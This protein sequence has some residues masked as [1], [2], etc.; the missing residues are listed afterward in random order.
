MAVSMNKIKRWSLTLVLFA[1]M[2][3]VTSPIATQTQAQ[4]GEIVWSEAINISNSPEL[5]STDPFLLADPAGGA[6]LFWAERAG[7]GA[8]LNPDTVMYSYWDGENWSRPIDIFFSP[9]SDGNPIVGY[10]H[11]L[12]DDNGRIHLFWLTEPNYPYYA[13]KYSSVEAS[14]ARF[15]AA[16]EPPVQL[17][18]D[19]TG[20]KYSIQIAYTPPD[21]LHL[22]Y[23]AGAQGNRPSEDRTVRYMRSTDLGE[24]W[25]EPLD[26]FTSPVLLW[27]TSDTRLISVSPGNLYASWTLWDD[28]GNGFQ[29]YFT[30]SRDNGLTWDTPIVLAEN[31]G[32]EYE[33]DWNNL[34]PLDK[35]LL[36]A[37]WEGGWRAYRQAQ[38][39]TDGGATWSEPIDT[40]P[41]LIGDNGFVEFAQDSNGTW[42]AFVAQRLR[43]GT[44]LAT[45]SDDVSLWHSVWQGG[46]SWSDPTPAISGAVAKNMTNPKVTIVNGNRIVAVWY[47]SQIYEIMVMTGVIPDAPALPPKPWAETASFPTK[48]ATEVR[49][50]PQVTATV[51]PTPTP[52]F[53]KSGSQAQDT[54]TFNILFGVVSSLLISLVMVV[55]VIFRGRHI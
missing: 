34:V 28:D 30:R 15:A 48:V 51:Q 3:V 29:I 6:H 32:D 55:M 37:M 4:S 54:T 27:G 46:P 45:L 38:Y 22:I 8:A 53:T 1:T 23:S 42:H 31:R 36:M 7:T 39:S 16:W 12:M 19:L 21:T 25:S 43:E 17:A 50:S 10:P 35:N 40:F 14:Q 5:T 52:V 2:I 44:E 20:S 26:L 18:D 13:L 49:S 33:R 24:T 47:G 11:A 9:E 41:K